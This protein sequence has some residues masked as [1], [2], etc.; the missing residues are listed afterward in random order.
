[1]LRAAP[2]RLSKPGTTV[3]TE[4][5]AFTIGPLIGLPLVGILVATL[6]DGARL[7]VSL[8]TRVWRSTHQALP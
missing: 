2:G 3:D 7:L 6:I 1:V 4:A 5:L 8:T